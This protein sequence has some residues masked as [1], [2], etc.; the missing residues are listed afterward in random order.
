MYIYIHTYIYICVCVY[1][2]TQITEEFLLSNITFRFYAHRRAY[3][4]PLKFYYL[5]IDKYIDTFFSNVI[6][7]VNKF[8]SY[9]IKLYLYE[10]YILS[11]IFL[12]WE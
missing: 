12:N 1:R 10:C 9:A 4:M 2:E 11:V 8:P 6:E 5:S 7:K 3:H